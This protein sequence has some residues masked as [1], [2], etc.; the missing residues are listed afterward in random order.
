MHDSK[1]KKEGKGRD[2][3]QSSTTSDPG[4][5]RESD[6]VTNTHQKRKPKKSALSQQLTTRHQ[7]TDEQESISKQDRNDIND[8]KKKHRSWNGQ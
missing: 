7:Q 5:Q 4:Y 8:Q 1:S 3:I 6:N 2:S